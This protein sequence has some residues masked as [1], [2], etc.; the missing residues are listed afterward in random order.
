MKS[1]LG[2]IILLL[3]GACLSPYLLPS[4]YMSLYGIT[5]DG[6]VIGKR[7]A[8]EFYGDDLVR[9]VLEVTYRYVPADTQR[10]ET[11]LH[12]V[13]SATY[14]RVRTGSPVKVRY[15]PSKVLR[16]LHVVALGS[17]LADVPW[18][19]RLPHDRE[20]ERL[21]FDL[22]AMVLAALLGFMA[23]RTRSDAVI[24][25]AAFCGAVVASAIV[26]VGFI[27]FPILFAA[28]RKWPGK[29]LGFA[30][31]AAMAVFIPVLHWRTP[32]DAPLPPDHAGPAPAT[33]RQISTVHRIWSGREGGQ[34]IPQPYQMVDLEFTPGVG[35]GPVHALDRVDV[36]SVAGMRPGTTVP[37][38][39][40]TANPRLA[41]IAGGSRTYREKAVAYLAEQAFIWS[42]AIMV[43]LVPCLKLANRIS[44][45]IKRLAATAAAPETVAQRIP[46]LR[47][48]DLRRKVLEKLSKSPPGDARRRELEEMAALSD[49]DL[50][51]RLFEKIPQFGPDDPRR[52]AFEKLFGKG[53]S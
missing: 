35:S 33:V 27:A 23:W 34:D 3:L 21:Y 22:S 41:Q 1:A 39:Y 11:G 5:T 17:V 19:S 26:P 46:A 4:V 52:K 45:P 49:E 48:S 44:R 18:R 24:L 32:H 25:A 51:R 43:V 40:S 50:R 13:D 12:Q 28:W 15:A 30:L 38:L 37:I 2:I 20:D 29:G 10:P 31:L 42:A 16:S 6:Q 47:T 8:I 53:E 36:D 14:D 7:E 9:H